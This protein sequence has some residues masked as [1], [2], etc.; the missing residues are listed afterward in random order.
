MNEDD[1][2][3]TLIELMIVVVILGVLSSLAFVSVTGI[4]DRVK[5]A[6]CGSDKAI[7]TF[8]GQ[9][10]MIQSARGAPAASLAALHTAG[11]LESVPAN[12]TYAP[13]ATSFTVVGIGP[14][15]D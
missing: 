12:V 4:S 6:S 8:A 1:N 11:L 3:Y 10:F 7:V 15:A 14:C 9:A 2:G 5:S 13:T